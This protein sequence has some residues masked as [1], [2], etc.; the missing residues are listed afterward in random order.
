MGA[1]Q[2]IEDGWQVR[3]CF[4]PILRIPQWRDTYSACVEKTFARLPAEK[5]RDV[6]IGVFRMNAD[7]YKRIKKQRSDSDILYTPYERRG[8]VVTLLQEE[9]E[10]VNSFMRNLLEKY[11]NKNSIE[12][13]G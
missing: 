2:A 11:V 5:I 4:D 12:L 10:E 7:Y 3:L 8:G 9:Q 6:S 1:A 13:W